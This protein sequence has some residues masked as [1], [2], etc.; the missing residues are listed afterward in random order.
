MRAMRPQDDAA[1]TISTLHFLMSAFADV[2]HD[3]GAA[4]VAARLPWI[5]PAADTPFPEPIA[6]PCVQ[7]Y[8][9]APTKPPAARAKTPAPGIRPSTS[10]ASTAPPDP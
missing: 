9:I 3:L 1:K 8:S 10:S 2:L 7:A 6:E 4:E 5:H